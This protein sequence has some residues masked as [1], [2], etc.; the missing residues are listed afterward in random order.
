M[1][2]HKLPPKQ[3]SG[4]KDFSV[5]KL[6]DLRPGCLPVSL[7][8]FGRAHQDHWKM[9]VHKVVGVLNSK[10]MEEKAGGGTKEGITISV[11]HPDKLLELGDSA[12][13][14]KCVHR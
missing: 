7:F 9:P 6:T 13:I 3:S 14:G 12:D 10:V 5:W 11:D 2:Q 8:L 1:L 4:G